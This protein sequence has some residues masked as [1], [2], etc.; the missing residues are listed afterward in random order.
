MY[1]QHA[2]EY[3]E[4][5]Q[6][7]REYTVGWVDFAHFFRILCKVMGLRFPLV[8]NGELPIFFILVQ[9]PV[10][11]TPLKVHEFKKIQEAK[12]KKKKNFVEKCVI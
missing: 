2:R 9:K 12:K 7:A 3:I 1:V 5:A 10:R 4:I 11:A 8:Q 6:H